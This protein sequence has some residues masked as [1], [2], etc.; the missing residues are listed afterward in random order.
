MLQAL[1][2][3]LS[4][5]ERYS[6]LA[7]T[8]R[9]GIAAVLEQL[10]TMHGSLQAAAAHLNALPLRCCALG[11]DAEMLAD[12]GVYN[13]LTPQEVWPPRHTHSM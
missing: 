11:A 7:F 4:H 8:S 12:A 13:V 6:H 1:D 5:L 3:E 10:A 2:Q 9:N